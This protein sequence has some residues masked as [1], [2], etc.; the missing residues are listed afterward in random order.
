M[1]CLSPWVESP[2]SFPANGKQKR[3]V[4]VSLCGH[5]LE[6]SW[7]FAPFCLWISITFE[8]DTVG[9]GGFSG[10]F[11]RRAHGD[12]AIFSVAILVWGCKAK[13]T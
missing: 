7:Y 13:S 6:V 1:N 10:S 11:G 3:G 5:I 8:E 4:P 9:V 12:G 2:H